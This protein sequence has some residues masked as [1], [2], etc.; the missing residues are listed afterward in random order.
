[1]KIAVYIRV[2]EVRVGGTES[3]FASLFEWMQNRHED[4]QFE[5]IASYVSNEK[6]L[7]PHILTK[8]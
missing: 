7:L 1:M 3:Y 8:N 4:S 2:M 5:V 6:C